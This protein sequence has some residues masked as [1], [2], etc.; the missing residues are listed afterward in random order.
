MSR[1]HWYLVSRVSVILSIFAT[2]FTLTTMAIHPNLFAWPW[3]LSSMC[4][5]VIL[6]VIFDF[7]RDRANN[8][9]DA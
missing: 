1:Q 2:A 4:A 7:A 9:E 3:T 6:L 5:A 8:D